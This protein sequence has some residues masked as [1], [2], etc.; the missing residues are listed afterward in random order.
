[1]SVGLTQHSREMVRCAL[2]PAMEFSDREELTRV[3]T[4]WNQADEHRLRGLI[5]TLI[6]GNRF[7]QLVSDNASK[8][9][10]IEIYV[11]ELF[12]PGGR[13]RPREGSPTSVGSRWTRSRQLEFERYDEIVQSRR[14]LERESTEREA[15]EILQGRPDRSV[16]LRD[17]MQDEKWNCSICFES[18]E[19]PNRIYV[20]CNAIENED[21]DYVQHKACGPCSLALRKCHI[22]RAP[23][24]RL[25]LARAW[26]GVTPLTM[27]MGVNEYLVG[28]S[29]ESNCLHQP[30]IK[31][32]VL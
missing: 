31:A 8:Q 29:R 2:F 3:L 5:W 27:Q 26:N 21:R 13:R 9:R 17:I 11:N 22:C 19:D 23:A 7:L 20:T 32:L 15:E 30:R 14:Q 28:V 4:G 12:S 16:E 25:P 24:K 18:F 10:L 6:G 1:M